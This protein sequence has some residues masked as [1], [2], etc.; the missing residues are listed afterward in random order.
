MVPDRFFGAQS[1]KETIPMPRTAIIVGPK[2]HGRRMS[3]DDF[4]FAEVPEGSTYELSRGVVVVSDVAALA[5]GKQIETIRDD[6]A[7]YRRIHPGIIHFVAGGSDCKLLVPET[8]S[9]RHP[10][11][12]IYKTPQPPGDNPWRTWIPD[13]VIEVVSLS[14][15]Q[16][17]YVDKREDYWQLGVKEY[18]IV[19]A[20]RREMLVLRRRP[21][22]WSPKTVRET[23]TY[24]TRLLPG[25]SLHVAAVF[26]AA[27][28]ARG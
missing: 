21:G 9:E 14:S 17:D 20:E 7:I 11:L 26:A 13:I 15:L 12:A 23:E 22:K 25:F 27:D 8:E 28:A 4:E 1:L 5:H 24:V 10:D 16:R 19:D 2:D 6:L 18:W 3:L